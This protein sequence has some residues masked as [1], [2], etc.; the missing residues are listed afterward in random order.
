MPKDSSV[1]AEL[2]VRSRAYLAP[3]EPVRSENYFSEA[4]QL[5]DVEAALA[6]YDRGEAVPFVIVDDD[7]A[8]AGRLTLSGIIR[9][10]FLSCAM[11]YWVA[12]ERAGRGL[13]TSA[14]EAATAHAFGTLGLHRVQA[15]TLLSN[16]ASQRVLCRNG[17]VQ[18]GVAPKYLKIAGEWQDHLMYQVL[19][20]DVGSGAR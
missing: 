4:G 8:L 9:G 3:W 5:A 14:V 20:D 6:R 17:F 15:E 19:V 12:E 2:Q 11:G 7:G 13:A 18:F 1:L 10:S 16:T